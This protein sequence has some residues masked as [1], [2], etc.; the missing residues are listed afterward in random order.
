[1]GKENM[2][3]TNNEVLLGR[4]EEW[5]HIICK[6]MDTKANK[7]DAERQTCFLSYVEAKIKFKNKTA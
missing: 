5:N 7:P 6:K 3:Y 1:M 4:K 2:V